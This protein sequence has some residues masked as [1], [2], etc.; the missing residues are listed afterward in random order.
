MNAT[1]LHRALN[2]MDNLEDAMCWQKQC[3]VSNSLTIQYDRA[4]YV[5]EPNELTNALRRKKV[6]VFDYPDGTIAIRHEGVSLPYSSFDKVSKVSQADVVSNK[7]L[8]AVL[9]FAKAQQA[10]IGLKRSQ[11]APGR[12]GQKQVYEE[13]QRRANPAVL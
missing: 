4:M 3:T 8:G 5:L 10:E 11:K 13:G 7:R 9:A 12:R 1:D 2:D 6:I